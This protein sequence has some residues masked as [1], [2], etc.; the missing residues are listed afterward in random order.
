MKRRLFAITLFL[1]LVLPGLVAFAPPRQGQPDLELT[2]SVGYNGYFQK[3]QW[4]PVR[5]AIGNAGDNLDGELR[6]RTGSN[7][8]LAETTYS[9][10][11]DLPQGARKQ[12]FLYVSLE[13]YAQKVQVEIVDTSGTVVERGSAELRPTGQGDILYAVVTGSPFGAVDLT[14]LWPGTG[15][16][17]Q[18]NWQ[19][20]EIPPLAD[21]LAG[22]DVL[23]FHD[24]DTG[25]LTA[26]QLAAITNWVLSGGHLLVV[27]GE[28]WQRTTSGFESMLP[29][30][31]EGAVPVD[32]LVSL[33]EDFLYLP[34]ETLD[35]ETTATNSTPL[36][37][38]RV[39]AAT[40]AVPLIVR[41]EHGDG[42]IDFLAVDPNSEPLRSWG[43]K[44][45]LWYTLVASVGQ[46]PSWANGFDDWSMAREATLTTSSTVLPTFL[47]LCGFLTLY[48]VLVGPVNYLILKRLNRREWA[49]FSIPIL[50]LIFSV[51]AYTVGFNLRGNVATVNRLTVVRSWSGSEQAQ[52]TSLIGV[53][54]PRRRS[55]DIAVERGYTLRT[56]PDIGTGL[57]VPA[58]IT[59]GTRYVAESI[60]I[61][62]GTVA[63]FTASGQGAAPALD[64]EVSW[65][66]GLAHMPRVE[67]RVTNTTDR[68]FEDAVV[69]VK[70]ESRYL[71]NLAPGETRSFD[72]TL[73][74][75]DPGSLTL[76]NPQNQY[77]PY[78]T[79]PWSYTSSSPGWCFSNTRGIPLTVPDVMRNEPFSCAT[80]GVT[81]RQQE[82]RRRYRLLASLVVDSDLSGG[83]DT[84]VYLFAWN[85]DAWIDV[86]L[87][88]RPQGTEDTTLYIFDLPV[89]VVSDSAQV[90]IPP[91]LTTWVITETDNPDTLRDIVP[92]RFQVGNNNHAAFQFMPMP[93]LDLD[94]VNELVI[95][96]QA[97]GPLYVE[98]WNWQRD[99]WERI[100][101]SPDS[102][103]TSIRN[104][105]RFVGPENAVNVRVLSQDAASYNRV[106]YV[107]VAYRGRLAG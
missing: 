7:G 23:M 25:A 27:G 106:D 73:G 37:T 29:V 13:S 104:P 14:A 49:W 95:Q 83:R 45:Y 17:Y 78:Y 40:G 75:Q 69:L 28:S 59:E 50:I 5:V 26:E 80:T 101:L 43:D 61:D 107:K 35:E 38:A 30:S 34:G 62:A 16:A 8:G 63:S 86:E 91:G 32:S 12:I 67:G 88:D 41:S 21:A 18:V 74:P 64:A 44:E 53:Q 15:N 76:G 36:P 11:L 66:L 47:Q 6:V 92:V 56:L 84:G 20:E 2:V 68:T 70:G 33:A 22:L 99:R 87:V 55:Y 71:G 94:E 82:I 100:R 60:P 93:A 3:G 51:L 97:S 54:S 102:D 24:V 96:F 48:I 19:L 79:G 4:T 65:H 58:L 10:P 31:L 89:S 1:T 103:A 72:I 57:S 90:E 98:L 46:R 85:E 77:S 105:A 52:V 42:V 39:L 81:P 9:T